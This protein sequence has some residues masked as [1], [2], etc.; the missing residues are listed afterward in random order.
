MPRPTSRRRTGRSPFGR[1]DRAPTALPPSLR[2]SLAAT[3]VDC[4]SDIY[5]SDLQSILN[6]GPLGVSDFNRGLASP[7]GLRLPSSAGTGIGRGF[8]QDSECLSMVSA[9]VGSRRRGAGRQAVLRRS[10][11]KASGGSHP[12]VL[13]YRNPCAGIKASSSAAKPTIA[14]RA[15]GHLGCWA[16]APAYHGGKSVIN[17]WL[18]YGSGARARSTR[19]STSPS[20]VGSS[21]SAW[22]YAQASEGLLAPSDLSPNC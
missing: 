21:G 5:F 19:C 3:T 9:R 1:S 15:F 2:V 10:T 13:E 8:L 6:L 17:Y 18:I 7:L 11:S 20:A 12:R 4:R 14:I 16:R 22:R